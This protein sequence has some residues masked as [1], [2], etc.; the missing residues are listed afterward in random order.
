M[1]LHDAQTSGGLLMAVNPDHAT[2]LLEELKKV[3]PEISA[4]AIGQVLP[5]S[6]R[7]LYFE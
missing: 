7:R 1:L 5:E 6:P 2:S 4:M 3:D